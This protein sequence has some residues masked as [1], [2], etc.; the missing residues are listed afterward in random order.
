LAVQ[1]K[2]SGT[3]TALVAQKRNKDRVNVYLDGTFAFGLAAIEAI[4]LKR[5]Q[6]LSETDIDRLREAD[7]VEKAHEKALRFLA[8]RPRSESEVRQNLK[9]AEFG[10]LAI[11]QVIERLSQSDLINDEAFVRYW[12]ENRSQ[13][14]PRGQRALRQELRQKGVA[15]EVIDA[16]LEESGDDEDAAATQAALAKANRYRHLPQPEF[17]QKLGA[18]LGRRGFDYETVRQAVAAAWQ[19]IHSDQETSSHFYPSDELEE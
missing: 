8:N 16:V 19:S 13:F 10:S 5:G 4:K 18:Y 9:K 12:I 1:E 3:I 2:M 6:V 11:D 7:E 15:R 17:A 14:N